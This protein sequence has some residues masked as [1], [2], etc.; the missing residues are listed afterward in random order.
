MYMELDELKTGIRSRLEEGIP[1]SSAT[2][3]TRLPKS[4]SPLAN[5]RRSLRI[6]IFMTVLLSAAY[7]VLGFLSD[8]RAF[9]VY[10]LSLTLLFGVVY[11]PVYSSLHRMIDRVLRSTPTVRDSVSALLV[12]LKKYRRL[13]ISFTLIIIP[14]CMVYS[15]L[16]YDHLPSSP[17]A[18]DAPATGRSD[19]GWFELFAVSAILMVVFYLLMMV[20][21]RWMY[22]RHIRD[23]ENTLAEFDEGREE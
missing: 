5:I 15:K 9:K 14:F 7:I 1:A 17:D 10:L 4:H 21:Y 2:E 12:V 11:I 3:M 16:L 8:D 6:E 19:I 13:S 20:Y 23:L 18:V 22:D